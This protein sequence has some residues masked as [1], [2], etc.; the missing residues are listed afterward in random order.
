M[1]IPNLGYAPYI[2]SEPQFMQMLFD[3][4]G[5][6]EKTMP[7][8]TLNRHAGTGM[9]E[10]LAELAAAESLTSQQQ[11]AMMGDYRVQQRADELYELMNRIQGRS[12]LA[13]VRKPT[14]EEQAAEMAEAERALTA[15][16]DAR[17]AAGLRSGYG[18]QP[19]GVRNNRIVEPQPA[20]PVDFES[21]EQVARHQAALEAMAAGRERRAGRSPVAKRTPSLEEE[22]KRAQLRAEQEAREVNVQR[23]AEDRALARRNRMQGGQAGG[24]GLINPVAAQAAGMDPR[25][26]AAHNNAVIQAAQMREDA[27]IRRETMELNE[28]LA[29]RGIASREKI[30]GME[31]DI[32]LTREDRED[33]R[34]RIKNEMAERMGQAELALRERGM[35]NEAN[36]LSRQHDETMRKFDRQIDAAQS[37]NAI[38]RI[39]TES[40]AKLREQQGKALGVDTAT[41]DVGS[42]LILTGLEQQDPAMLSAGGR[43]VGGGDI[44]QELAGLEKTQQFKQMVALEYDSE[45]DFRDQARK[46]GVPEATIDEFIAENELKTPSAIGQ[47][48]RTLFG[49][50]D[51]GA[52]RE[53]FGM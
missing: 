53:L 7:G 27:Q 19:Y 28:R 13:G 23:R 2:Y 10:R 41:R 36:R 43:L 25:M 20:A 18:T 50:P 12:P 46:L 40:M 15:R 17:A 30:A 48:G 22:I 14:A 42:Q 8:L 16:A 35:T 38:A 34:A 51:I 31:R 39:E 5:V 49:P 9:E 44:N 1:P 4:P 52:I 6:T 29:G 3:R 45:A 47:W 37:A 33:E 24:Q 11:D 32:Q 26:V 21:P